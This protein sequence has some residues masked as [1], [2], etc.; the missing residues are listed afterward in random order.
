MP[1]NRADIDS[2]EVIKDFRFRLIKF[3][4]TA[5]QA[6]AGIT[7]DIYRVSAWLSHDQAKYWTLELRKR[8][9]EFQ[10][11]KLAF[12]NAKDPM[13]AYRKDSAVDERKEMRLC[14]TRRDDAE[15]KLKAVKRWCML[16]DR[17]SQEMTGPI[18]VF[19]GSL[20]ANTPKAIAKLDMLI[21]KLEEYLR[22]VAPDVPS[23]G[24]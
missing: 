19:A 24:V 11:S 12:K 20:D 6:I 8:E 18:N 21:T 3:D 1:L 9:E 23:S 7:G 13:S 17:E 5:R 10:L 14:E 15:R 2:P 4:E 22:L 16:I